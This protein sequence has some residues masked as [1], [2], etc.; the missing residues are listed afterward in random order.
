ML[1]RQPSFYLMMTVEL[2]IY[3]IHPGGG[4]FEGIKRKWRV[5]E[6]W[7]CEIPGSIIGKD[8]V[9][10]SVDGQKLKRTWK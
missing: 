9:S 6:T 3:K 10:V 5:A 7:H 2:V 4:G 8:A 1:Q